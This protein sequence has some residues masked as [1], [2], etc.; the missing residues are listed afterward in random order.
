MS[1]IECLALSLSLGSTL[2]C[3]PISP[4]QRGTLATP[5]MNPEDAELEA[6]FHS[7]IEAA[8]EAGM[9]GHGGRG[10]GCGCG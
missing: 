5:E 9:G 8:R 3:A 10:G 2:A 6:S 1:S 4:A 7:H